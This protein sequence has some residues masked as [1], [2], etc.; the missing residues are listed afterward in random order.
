[1][2]SHPG[3]VEVV[4]VRLFKVALDC[5]NIREPCLKIKSKKPLGTEKRPRTVHYFCQGGVEFSWVGL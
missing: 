1:M 2:K 3:G 4:V 5:G